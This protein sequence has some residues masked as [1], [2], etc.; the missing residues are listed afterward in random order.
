[1]RETLPRLISSTMST[2][3]WFELAAARAQRRAKMPGT[4]S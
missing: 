4:T 3:S 1:M 2:N